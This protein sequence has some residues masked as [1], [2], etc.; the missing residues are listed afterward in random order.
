[1][2]NDAKNLTILAPGAESRS[3]LS[4]LPRVPALK[5][6]AQA[7]R[8]SLH[9]FKNL[10]IM[11]SATALQDVASIVK[12][13][14]ENKLL[15]AL[16]VRE[17]VP[18]EW[19]PQ[20]FARADL[21]MVRNT[22]IHL[23]GDWTTPR[24]IIKAWQIGAQHDLIARANIIDNKLFLLN[25]ALKPFEISF[26]DLPPL[27]KIPKTQRGDFRISDSGSY[28]HWPANDIHLDIE[29][30]R[31]FTDE[32]FRKKCDLEKVTHDKQFGLAIATMRKTHHLVQ[33]DIDGMS[34]R[35]LRRIENE[36]A[37]PS[38]ATLA[39]LAKAHKMEVNDYLNELTKYL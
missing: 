17:D 7:N 32:G 39:T 15:R 9:K 34:D 18:P 25:C 3:L 11:I 35:Q 6:L 8:A 38:V 27:N 13:A 36:G 24:R 22:V 20:M 30:I 4:S 2:T 1:M 19:L 10:F 16:F 14:N 21:R 28:I 23:P 26:A 37:R 33:A 31:Y 12:V 29:S 5:I